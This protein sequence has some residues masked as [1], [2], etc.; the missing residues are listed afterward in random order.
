MTNQFYLRTTYATFVAAFC[1]ATPLVAQTDANAAP[2][3]LTINNVVPAT[4]FSPDAVTDVL[5]LRIGMTAAEFDAALA[6]TGLPLFAH[7]KTIPDAPVY[8][9]LRMGYAVQN[10]DVT[11]QFQWADGYKMSFEPVR[12]SAGLTMYSEMV[13]AAGASTPL[14]NGQHLWA[15]FGGPSVGAH[16]QEIRRSTELEKPVDKQTMIDSITAK[17]G[18]PSWIKEVGTFWVEIYYYYDDGLLITRDHR[19]NIVLRQNCKPTFFTGSTPE[20]LYTDATI[21]GWYGPNKDPR[22]SKQACDAGIF[23]RLMFGDVPNTIDRLDVAIMDNVARWENTSA[24]WAQ[25]EAAHAEWL[26]S[27]AGS[28]TAPDL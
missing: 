23:V 14:V 24:I 4:G 17:Y 5:G 16:V 6:I 15:A 18:T 26:L 28:K 7:A 13:D 12:A 11:P 10:G 19:S 3:A 25:A 20:I 27:V 1:L 2:I 21:N 9:P 22:T 8:G